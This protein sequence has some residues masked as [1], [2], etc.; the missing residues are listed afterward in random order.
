MSVGEVILMFVLSIDY[1]NFFL[2][3]GT[4]TVVFERL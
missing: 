3:H 4:E 1:L 2:Y